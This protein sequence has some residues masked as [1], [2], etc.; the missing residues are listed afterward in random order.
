MTAL[1][2][3]SGFILTRVW[4]ESIEHR[5]RPEDHFDYQVG[6]T[7]RLRMQALSSGDRDAC[8]ERVRGRLARADEGQYVFRGQVVMALATKQPAG[9]APR[10]GD[11]EEGRR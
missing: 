8:L 10:V 9:T 7:S 1:L 4:S 6:S 5:W 2:E 11:F 3:Q